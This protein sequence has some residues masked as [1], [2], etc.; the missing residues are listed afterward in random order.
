MDNLFI[1]KVQILKFNWKKIRSYLIKNFAMKN[2]SFVDRRVEWKIECDFFPY[3]K[4]NIILFLIKIRYR[5][6]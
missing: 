3:C 2:F 6:I 5:R 4:A 1:R